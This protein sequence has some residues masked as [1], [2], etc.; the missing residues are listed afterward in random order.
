MIQLHE[1]NNLLLYIHARGTFSP[2]GFFYVLSLGWEGSFRRHSR[3]RAKA[4]F[5]VQ[6]LS[7]G[8]KTI[9]PPTADGE[10]KAGFKVQWLSQGWWSIL[11]AK[12]AFRNRFGFKTL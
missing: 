1:R 4:G 11:Q 3:H 12:L 5:K 9:C 10:A 7:Q 2:P 6:R 8:V